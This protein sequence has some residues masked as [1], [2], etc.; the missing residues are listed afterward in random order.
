M[1]EVA[2]SIRT[3]TSS[4]GAAGPLK[5]TVVFRRVRPRSSAPSVRLGPSTS[6][7]SMRPTRP[8]LRAAAER[9]TTSIRRAIRSRLTSS[10]TWSGIAAASVPLRGEK[11]NVKAPS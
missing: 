7:S 11:T 9:W 8:A 3:G 4:P 6:T 1:V 5:L 2:A 10:G